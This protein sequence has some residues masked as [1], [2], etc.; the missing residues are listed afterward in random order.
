MNGVDDLLA[1]IPMADLAAR[2]GV[3]EEQAAAATRVALP[4]LV[5][6]IQANAADP[7]GEASLLD[8]LNQHGSELDGGIDLGAIDTDDGEKIVDHVFGDNRDAVVNRLGETQAAGGVLDS[9]LLK[10]LLPMLAPLIMAFL[11]KKMGGM[12]GGGGT[13]SSA[14]APTSTDASSSTPGRPGGTGGPPQG[15]LND[16]LGGGL[17]D[18]LDGGLGDILGGLLG[19]GR[20]A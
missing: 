17:G 14:V 11:A 15:S 4:T 2:L 7:G 13:T 6:G 12:F 9:G 19:G 1:Q 20:K 5:G 8:A 3:S 10:K 16:I 18:I